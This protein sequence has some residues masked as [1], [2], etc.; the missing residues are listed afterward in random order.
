MKDIDGFKHH[1]LCKRMNLT[2][3]CFADDLLVFCR[4]DWDSMIVSIRA[5]NTFL[6]AF[7]LKINKQ[8]SNVYG[9]GMPREI[10]E[11]FALVSG[12]KIGT[13]PFKY[14]GVRISAKK[15]SVLDCNILVERI[16]DRIRALGAKK[17]SYTS[18]LVMI[19]SVLGA[20]HSYWARIYIIP[21][22]I[23]TKLESICINFLWKGQALS[24]SPTLVAWDRVC[25][26]KTQGGLGVC[27]LRRWNVAAVG[28]GVA[29]P[30]NVFAGSRIDSL[31]APAVTWYNCI[32]NSIHVPKQQ[33]IGWLWIQGRLL[34]KDRLRS[35]GISSD[36]QCELC[37]DAAESHE[38]LFFG[39]EYSQRCL[40]LVNGWCHSS[41]PAQQLM[42]WWIGLSQFDHKDVLVAVILALI[43]H[44]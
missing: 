38:H 36:T 3:L 17:L 8:K 21:T 19:K 34:T 26:P 33:F 43:Y 32:W 2:H 20:L 42:D 30:G 13:L 37:G 12:L 4:G 10:L 16:V 23:M 1:P 14:L 6:A 11:K 35:I 25:L 7:G 27:D 39:C 41:I 9:N 5:F 31:Q 15:L 40:Q 24:H 28:R 18:R 29:G 22:C 44:I